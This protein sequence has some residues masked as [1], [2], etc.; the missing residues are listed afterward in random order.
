MHLQR[1]IRRVVGAVD[2]DAAH[3]K[4]ALGAVVTLARDGIRLAHGARPV[5]VHP[6]GALWVEGGKVS[7]GAAIG[8]VEEEMLATLAGME[9]IRAVAT[10]L[11]DV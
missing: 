7:D 10:R 6:L 4:R 11:A 5:R 2:A 3:R 1:V 9:R 8:D